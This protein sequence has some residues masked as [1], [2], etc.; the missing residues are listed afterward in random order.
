[1][2]TWINRHETFASLLLLFLIA[3]ICFLPL[4]N[5]TGY[6]L[7]DW[8][9]LSG[10]LNDASPFQL[11]AHERLG[12]GLLYSITYPVLGDHLF[13][14]QLFSI[15]LRLVSA[16]LFWWLTR[17]I[18]K[19]Q[20]YFSISAAIIFLVYPG[21]MQQSIAL[22][23]SNHFIGVISALLS[24]IFTLKSLTCSSRRKKNIY[25]SAA[26]LLEVA[27]LFNYE[28]MLGY[29]VVRIVLIWYIQYKPYLSAK[30]WKAIKP[31][32]I[33]S[34]PYLISLG[35][36]LF[37]RVFLFKSSRSTTSMS[38]LSQSY[39]QQP[40][41]M[42]SRILLETIRDFIESV[43]VAWSVP[44]NLYVSEASFGK[45]VISICLA[46]IAATIFWFFI[47]K[48]S[49]EQTQDSNEYGGENKTHFRDS[50]WIGLIAVIV[51]LL[52]VILSN[53]EVMFKNELD[54]YT[55]H[56]TMGVSLFLVGFIFHWVKVKGRK[57]I[58]IFLLGLAIIIQFNN[59]A[60]YATWWKYQTDL[61]W[62]LSWRAPDIKDGTVVMPL[63]PDR[64]RLHEA[65]EAWTPL[66]VIYRPGD[67]IL[68]TAEVINPESVI[69]MLSGYKASRTFREVVIFTREFEFPLIISYPSGGSCAHIIDGERLELSAA[70]ESIIY[71][72]ASYSQIDRI[73]PSSENHIPPSGLFGKE[74]AHDWC[75]YYQKVSLFRQLGEW[76]TASDLADQAIEAGLAPVD[77]SEYLPFIESYLSANR[78]E[79]AELLA[80]NIRDDVRVQQN[81]CSTW[82]FEKP[83]ASADLMNMICNP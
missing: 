81:L 44:F 29:E 76:D 39:L 69:D 74:P 35:L 30:Y 47:K 62:Q 82:Q 77:L 51:A 45:F 9:P 40:I 15:G 37:W 52:P 6:Y 70:D 48:S 72:I 43:W 80:K 25:I 34:L 53:R 10:K 61:W 22:T 66:Q 19:D 63:L 41:T 2:K 49:S 59:T 83:H 65:E 33:S 55:L 50:F 79:S 5:Q 67:P 17:I 14:W 38:L 64:Y 12:V 71:R 54:R 26:I 3:I 16:I 31:L 75:Y 21:F 7:N 60:Y 18:W 32:L 11:W 36:F 8:H 73:I 28:Y 1:M 46:I 42:T 57:F 27:Y 23:F 58:L 78:T 56:A 20:K 13:L 4:S 68:I 24:I